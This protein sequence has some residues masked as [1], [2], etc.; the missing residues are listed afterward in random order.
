MKIVYLV[1]HSE[2]IKKGNLKFIS[3]FDEQEL[4]ERLPLSISGETK[5][6]N[7]AKK[8]F[9]GNIDQIWSS[10]YERAISTAKY[11]AEFN[12]LNINVSV[13]F[14]E[15]KLGIDK[16]LES[17]GIEEGD[18]VKILDFEFEYRK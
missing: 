10:S 9:D 8:F 4:N 18:I 5:A 11:I 17:M 14:N 6:Y 12:D 1:R 15:R 3:N 13:L 16:K 7:M 2:N